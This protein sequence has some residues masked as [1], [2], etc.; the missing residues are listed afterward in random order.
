MTIEVKNFFESK[1]WIIVHLNLDD[2]KLKEFDKVFGDLVEWCAS[3]FGLRALHW[4]AWH[5]FND[6]KHYVLQFQFRKEEDALLFIMQWGG[7]VVS[8][9]K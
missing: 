1:G 9:I 6:K 4:D 8:K 7:K 5:A 2:P 3:Q